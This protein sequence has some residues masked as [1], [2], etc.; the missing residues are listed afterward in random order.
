MVTTKT[1]NK[2]ENGIPKFNSVQ[3]NKRIIKCIVVLLIQCPDISINVNK[4]SPQL[5]ASLVRRSVFE[6]RIQYNN[7]PIIMIII[8]RKNHRSSKNIFQAFFFFLNTNNQS[9]F[10]SLFPFPASSNFQCT[11]HVSI[12][13]ACIS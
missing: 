3:Q 10:E 2:V 13:F 9:H 7:G 5:F 6:I 12:Y 4:I 11:F 1:L 8:C